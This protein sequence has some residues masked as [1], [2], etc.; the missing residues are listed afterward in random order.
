MTRCRHAILIGLALLNFLTGCALV[1]P[2]PVIN[3]KHDN[4]ASLDPQNWYI[5]YSAGVPSSPTPDANGAWAFE[6]PDDASGGH[7]NYVQTPFQMTTLLHNVTVTF[8]VKSS[9]AQYSVLDPTDH[10][11]ATVHLF[12]EQRDDVLIDP[13][14][15]WWAGASEYDL[16]SEDGQTMQFVIPLTPDQ[17]TNVDGQSNSEG[18][19]NSLQNIGWI[20]LTFGGQYFWGHGVAMSGGSAQFVLLSLQVN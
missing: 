15:R 17:W 7:V 18:F 8:V 11:P 5:F 3:P 2:P 6:F 16:G 4:V 20:G 10:P 13:D 9:G 12:F 1:S 14:G 19:Y